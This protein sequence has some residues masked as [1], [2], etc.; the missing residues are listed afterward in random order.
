MIAQFQ[1]VLALFAPHLLYQD[2]LSQPLKTRSHS[3][4]TRASDLPTRVGLRASHDRFELPLE[5]NAARAARARPQMGPVTL[6]E[7]RAQDEGV[8]LRID[9]LGHV[10]PRGEAVLKAL[11]LEFTPGITSLLCSNGAGKPT[12]IR[13][14]ATLTRPLKAASLRCFHSSP[15]S[16]S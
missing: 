9:H 7:F 6:S 4:V 2:T 1:F 14:L 13:I 12:L 10:Y 16:S 15:R 3:H 8:S 11:D 5:V